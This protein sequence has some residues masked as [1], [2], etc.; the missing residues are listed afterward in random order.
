MDA[1]KVPLDHVS[2]RTDRSA[3]YFCGFPTLQHIKHK[4]LCLCP[5]S[6][7]PQRKLLPK[8]LYTETMP[9]LEGK[10]NINTRHLSTF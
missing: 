3:L 8:P 9:L 5:K 4:V 10:F 2:R 7:E 6:S 1:W